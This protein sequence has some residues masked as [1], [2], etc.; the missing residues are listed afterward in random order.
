MTYR[1]ADGFRTALDERLSR[2]SRESGLP[3]DRLRKYAAFERFLA[4]VEVATP[5]SWVLK[6][7]LAIN[8]RLGRFSRPSRDVDLAHG[9]AAEEAVEQLIVASRVATSQQ[10]HFE[11]RVG[12]QSRVTPGHP[13]P[14]VRL[15]LET[16]LASRLYDLA[17]I[18][19]VAEPELIDRAEVLEVPSLLG[20]AEL[21]PV[22]MLVTPVERHLADKVDAYLRG[23]INSRVIS[24]REKDLVDLVLLAGTERPVAGVLRGELDAALTLER[25]LPD[26]LPPPPA[27]WG[28]GYRLL[29]AQIGI[30]ES[31]VL[32][33]FEHARSLIDPIL[34]GSAP[35][36]ARWNPRSRDWELPDGESGRR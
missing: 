11:F 25:D 36:A 19:I 1:T 5:L 13:N 10:D 21:L 22:T 24:T 15:R 30:E 7:G 32:G 3:F 35:D 14:A 23:H 2:R 17:S 27:S 6:G 20:F 4:R 12:L 34:S 26:A 33:A 9:S 18:D 28:P 29:A 8:C 16:H 31:T